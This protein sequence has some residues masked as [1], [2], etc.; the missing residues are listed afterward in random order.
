MRNEL[1]K[2]RIILLLCLWMMASMQAIAQSVQVK[3]KVTDASTSEALPGV[4]IILKGTTV[5][6]ITAADGSFNLTAPKGGILVFSFIGFMG[7]EI[8]IGD[9][10]TI[11]VSLSPELTKLN[12]VVVIG[13]GTVKKADATGSVAV[14]SSNDFNKGAISSPQDLLI[15]KSAGVVV[16]T[17]GGAPGAGSTI[18]IRGGSSMSASNDPLIVID[19]V[20]IGNTSIPG[21]S[22]PLATLNPNDVE[23]FTILKDASATAIYGS[24][25]SNGVIIITTK[26]G[27]A[28]KGLV[29]SYSVNVSV[30]SAPAYVNV[31]SGDEFRAMALSLSNQGIAGLSPQA[32]T[33]LG[34]EN[35]NWQ[36]EIYQNAIG[37]DHNLSFSGAVK[38]INL[39]YRASVGYTNQDGILKTTNMKR[40]TTALGIDPTLLDDHLKIN[41]NAKFMNSK[42]NFGNTGAIGAAA[43]YD[44][45]Q[46]VKNGNT[47]FG[48]YTTWVNL[49]DTLPN[50]KM[51]PNGNPNSIG[52]SNPVALLEQTD[53]TS[54]VNR[55]L[56]NI[57]MD[58]KF[59]FLPDLHANLNL[60]YD[61]FKSTGHN[62]APTDAAWTFASGGGQVIN[63]SGEGKNQLLD[64]TLTYNKDLP[65]INSKITALAGYSWSHLWSSP[66]SYTQNAEGTLPNVPISQPTESFLI[67]F[68]GRLN[69]IFAD[70]YLLTFT[71]RDDGSSRFAPAN[72]WGLFPSAAFAWKIKEESFLKNVDGISDL[73]LRL[74]YGITGQQ[75]I[76]ADYPYLPVY[77]LSQPT[78]SYQFGN[79]FIPTYRP[80]AYDANIKWEQTST[81]NIGLDFGFL[82]NRITGSVDVYKR[83][84]TNMINTIPIAAGS[85]FSNFLT[86]N[87]GSMV[88][89][90][91]EL[92]LDFRAISQKDLSWTVGFNMGYNQNKVTK[93]TLTDDPTYPGVDFGLIAGGVGNYIQ[94]VRVGYPNNSFYVFQQV[95][96]SN[97]MPIEGLY[98]DRSGQGGTVSGND[99]NKY[100][101]E[102][103]APKYTMGISTRLQ[104]KSID[105]TFSGRANI[106]NYVYNN[107]ASSATYSTIY[108]QS[109][110]FNNVPKLINDSKFVNPQYFSDFYIENASFFRMDNMS[111]GYTFNKLFFE[112]LNAHLSF[113]VQNAFVITKYKGLDPEVDGGI[114]NNLYPRPRV[115]MLGLNVTF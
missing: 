58:Y 115:Y 89:Q 63:Y 20:P 17:D 65:A 21:M 83:I 1:K 69:Y 105:F 72:R 66:Y 79:T 5:G 23:S 35:T 7:E 103:P 94:N 109:G 33:R 81:D 76:G 53:N 111:V 88:N 56:G 70:K 67:S 102:Q 92:T 40:I 8:V 46:P 112:K 106:G 82:N 49:S 104:V 32:L 43:A 57:T 18:R 6:T 48:G 95:Y 42:T 59:H 36:K 62:D 86:T 12:E 16:T 74:G 50:G 51:N 45:T 55:F 108:N 24:R 10:S 61:A 26:R 84:T 93:L 13:Y 15:G 14:V 98:V 54:E 3:G 96:G 34:S 85:N 2:T 73:K 114:D 4:N 44:P 80:N 71:L 29:V 97:G 60:A 107:L 75:N 68:F 64:F 52:V 113:T 78:A 90:G 110:F 9:Q 31:L 25:A 100:H 39:P 101:Y 30:S 37:Q 41:V 11:N 28:E 27:S 22:N 99:L 19:G 91:T 77:L 47:R 38:S 87:V